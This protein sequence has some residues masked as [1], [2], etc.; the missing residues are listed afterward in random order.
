MSYNKLLPDP[1]N[2]HLF[3]ALLSQGLP[4][5]LFSSWLSFRVKEARVAEVGLAGSGEGEASK[6]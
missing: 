4:S 5:S 2:I 6:E 1:P 3:L